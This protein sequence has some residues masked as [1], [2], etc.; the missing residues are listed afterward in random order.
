MV[1]QRNDDCIGIPVVVQRNLPQLKMG[2]EENRIQLPL[3]LFSSHPLYIFIVISNY[4]RL[5]KVMG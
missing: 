4:G 5:H 2:L 3:R 1:I